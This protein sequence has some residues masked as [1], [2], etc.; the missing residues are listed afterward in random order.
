VAILEMDHSLSLSQESWGGSL[1]CGNF[2]E[3]SGG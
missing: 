1:L 2:P 3:C